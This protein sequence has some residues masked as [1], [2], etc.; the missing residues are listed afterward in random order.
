ML[1]QRSICIAGLFLSVSG[2]TQ[3]AP[4]EQIDEATI[5]AVETGWSEAFV[6]GDVAALEALLDPTYIS[7][8]ANGKARPKT[9][10]IAIAASYAAKHPGQHAQPLPATSI[11]ELMGDA[12]LVRHRSDSDVSIDLFSY[13][14]GHW[15]AR[16]SQHTAI[17]PTP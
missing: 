7:I 8:G 6:T 14:R 4:V 1:I 10:I 3:A 15:R 2:A 17:A 5:R 9:E 12:A 13:E 11:V 16:Y